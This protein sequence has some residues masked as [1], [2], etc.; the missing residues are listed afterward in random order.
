MTPLRFPQP[1]FACVSECLLVPRCLEKLTDNEAQRDAPLVHSL[2]IV[3]DP[4]DGVWNT[5][6]DPE[7]PEEDPKV[8][9]RSIVGSKQDSEAD[10]PDYGCADI[11]D[12]SFARTVGCPTD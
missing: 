10:D 12:A 3:A 2:Y 7:R 8:A 1:T 4:R 6:V 9:Q 5:R 11:E